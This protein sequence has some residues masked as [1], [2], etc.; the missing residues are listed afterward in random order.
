[1]GFCKD[2][3][4]LSFKIPRFLR[5]LLILPAL[6]LFFPGFAGA[7]P[8]APQRIVSL[9]PNITDILV[10]LG[11]GDRIVGV[12]KF[13]KKPNATAQ[14]IADYNS[15]QVEDVLRLKP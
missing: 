2:P 1:M 9:K 12:T 4:M 6:S 8:P 14:V 13:C 10:D 15:I 3:N 5:V 11:L 7:T